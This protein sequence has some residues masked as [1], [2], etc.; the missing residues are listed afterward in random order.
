MAGSGFKLTCL[1]WVL[2]FGSSV[3]LGAKFKVT[4]Q[5]YMEVEHNGHPLGRVVF[6]LFGE[7]APKT[8]E[9]FRTICTEGVDQFGT[10]KGSKF[11]RIIDKFMIQGGDIVTG[12]GHGAI[13]IYGKYFEDENL[14]INHT[15]PG[16]VAM[17]NRGPDTNGCQF[18]VTTMVAPWLNGKHTIF[19]K[20]VE[21]QNVI[22][23]VEKV[24]TDTDDF[25]VH[26]VIITDC[27]D[28]P[29]PEPFLI[30]DDPYE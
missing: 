6:G 29:L 12:D 10:Y 3:V 16:F 2:L 5:V 13:S 8:V 7:D 14:G 22:H 28:E 24:K 27:G 19:G 20:V 25:P 1:C 30:S 26:P 17:A 9:N 11:H 23:S 4:S 18:Y 21:G 15:G